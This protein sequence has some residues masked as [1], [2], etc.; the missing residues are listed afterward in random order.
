MILIGLT[1]S[2]NNCNY[3]INWDDDFKYG[4]IYKTCYAFIYEFKDLRFSNN[5]NIMIMC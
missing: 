5:M 4:I 3:S 1:I 2:S